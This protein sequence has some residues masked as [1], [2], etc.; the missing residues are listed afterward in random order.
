M[1]NGGRQKA[2]FTHAESWAPKAGR[3]KKASNTHSQTTLRG[4][5]EQHSIRTIATSC[6]RFLPIA[7]ICKRYVC[8][9]VLLGFC[10]GGADEIG[11]RRG[12]RKIEPEFLP[13]RFIVRLTASEHTYRRII[14]PYFSIISINHNHHVELPKE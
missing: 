8:L 3:S 5:D 13:M 9:R 2:S 1:P 10:T 12:S 6:P 11:R 4:N 14:L 7:E